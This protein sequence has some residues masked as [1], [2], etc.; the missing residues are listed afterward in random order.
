MSD[1]QITEIDFISPC[2]VQECVN[3]NKSYRWI[4]SDCGGREKLNDEGN[5]RCL[6][7][8][9]KGKFVDWKFNCGDHDYKEVSAQGVSHALAVM[10]QLAVE[11]SQQR[12]IAKTAQA[13]MKQILEQPQQQP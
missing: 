4:H 12:F 11:K 3:K 1:Q 10:A 7:C 2:P 13:I 5:L 6:K 8:A 9:T